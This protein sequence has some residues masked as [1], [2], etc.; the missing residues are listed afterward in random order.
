MN[1]SWL[2]GVTTPDSNSA[3]L[4]IAS[5]SVGPSG[6]FSKVWR[7]WARRPARSSLES[8]SACLW[9]SA[10]L[11]MP[12]FYFRHEILQAF[13]LPTVPFTGAGFCAYGAL[14]RRR[15]TLCWLFLFF[16]FVIL[17]VG[18]T[19]L[20]DWH[21]FSSLSARRLTTSGCWSY[22]LFVSARS[23]PTLNRS[24][25]F[26]SLS[27]ISFQSP[28]RIANTPLRE[29]CTKSWRTDLDAFNRVGRRLTE[30]SAASA[31]SS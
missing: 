12:S 6:A 22:R 16:L 25:G 4:S 21:C 13:L 26:L 19:L 11:T 10:S 15:A 20:P 8:S 2:I 5:W 30:S 27:V 18:L 14:P 31:G 28:S 3:S 23:L 1:C 7:R 29:W 24:T 9:I 17:L